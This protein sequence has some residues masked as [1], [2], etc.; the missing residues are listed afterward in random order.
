MR[1]QKKGKFFVSHL[2]SSLQTL[3]KKEREGGG[4]FLYT[5]VHVSTYLKQWEIQKQ[6]VLLRPAMAM[7][8][9]SGI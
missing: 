4:R 5:S 2:L 1:E 9:D 3:L 6:R 7:T 8:I